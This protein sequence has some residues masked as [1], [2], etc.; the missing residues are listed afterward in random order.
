APAAATNA[1]AFV[2]AAG[3]LVGAHADLDAIL[4]AA[5]RA[6][7]GDQEDLPRLPPLGQRIAI[8]ADQAFCF[9]YPHQLD[10]WRAAGAEL[11]FFSPLADESPAELAD[12]VFLPGGYPELHAGMLSSA[13][14][15]VRGMKAAAD[16]GTRIYGECGGYMVLGDAL[17]DGDGATHAMLGLL[18]LATSFADRRLSLGHRSLVVREPADLPFA[19]ALAGHEFH[20][21]TIVHE[22][23]VTADRLF[24]AA[25]G[26]GEPVGPMG[27]V[28]GSIMGS[29]AHVIGTANR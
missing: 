1:A 6:A 28:R 8:A 12:A 23:T 7:S 2:A 14:R 22:D 16:R 4:A 11:S 24:D 10:D 18:P 13:E 21:A 3:A 17:T 26:F 20:Y 15:F 25:D 9:C 27:L 19:S 29:F 5:T